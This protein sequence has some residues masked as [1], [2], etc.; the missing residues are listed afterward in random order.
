MSARVGLPNGAVAFTFGDD[1]PVTLYQQDGMVFKSGVV[2]GTVAHTAPIK[3]DLSISQLY[4][5]AIKS[6][7]HVKLHSKA[8][9]EKVN[10]EQRKAKI[11]NQQEISYAE[12][13]PN[14]GKAGIPARWLRIKK[15]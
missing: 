15:G 14:A 1:H 7:Q 12:H 11:A 3:T 8:D 6:G 9:V 2:G 5:N 4:E 10:A 13:H